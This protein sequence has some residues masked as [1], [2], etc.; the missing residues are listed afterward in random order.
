[1]PATDI[2]P[3]VI[4]AVAFPGMGGK[5]AAILNVPQNLG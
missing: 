5:T 4:V 2:A 1:M 3:Q